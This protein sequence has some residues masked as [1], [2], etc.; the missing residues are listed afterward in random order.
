MMVEK[1]KIVLKM[2]ELFLENLHCYT[3]VEEQQR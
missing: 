2:E 1:L 3:I